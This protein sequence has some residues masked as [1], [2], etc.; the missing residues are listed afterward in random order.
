[1]SRYQITCRNCPQDGPDLDDC[2]YL[3]VVGW[4]DDLET[5]YGWVEDLRIRSGR[6]ED[7]LVRVGA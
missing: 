3:V 4:E 7:L 5:Y 2:P 6:P 1:M